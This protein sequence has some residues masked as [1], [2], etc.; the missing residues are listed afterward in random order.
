MGLVII[1]VFAFVPLVRGIPHRLRGMVEGFSFYLCQN[2][3]AWHTQW[4]P[5]RLGT[6]LRV[7]RLYRIQAVFHIEGGMLNGLWAVSYLY[8]V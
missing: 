3:G 2:G 5:S 8:L 6:L 1:T 7:R 4:G